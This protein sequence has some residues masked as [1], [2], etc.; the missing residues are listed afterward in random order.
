VTQLGKRLGEIIVNRYQYFRRNNFANANTDT[1][2]VALYDTQANSTIWYTKTTHF[3]QPQDFWV[4]GT[5]PSFFDAWNF[6]N[7]S[8]YSESWFACD[9]AEALRILYQ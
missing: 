8:F 9:Q 2:I 6:S 5:I 7:E 4:M 1:A 3:T